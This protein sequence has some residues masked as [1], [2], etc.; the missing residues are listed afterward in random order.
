MPG[1]RARA[2][3]DISTGR[4][5]LVRIPA[6]A[7]VVVLTAAW[8]PCMAC[9]RPGLANG[10]P[11]LATLASCHGVGATGASSCAPLIRAPGPALR[12]WGIVPMA[13]LTLLPPPLRELWV[14][15][16]VVA[17]KQLPSLAPLHRPPLYLLH[18][19]LLA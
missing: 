12:A 15:R 5:R 9:E 1:S 7:L 11:G 14:L 17:W 2:A 3:S 18:G 6:L 13:G 4:H 16:P 19:S 10:S 8:A